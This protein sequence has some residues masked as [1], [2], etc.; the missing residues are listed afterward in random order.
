MH[1]RVSDSTRRVEGPGR[2]AAA[3]WFLTPDQRGN[4]ATGIDRRHADGRSWTSG[5]RVTVLVDGAEYFARLHRELC[6]LE[7]GDRVHLTDWEG[8]PDERLAGPGSEIG[9]VMSVG[10]SVA[11][12]T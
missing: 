11:V 10:G 9:A 1:P 2:V 5:N 8:D 6:R 4:P 12:A 3:D 7:P